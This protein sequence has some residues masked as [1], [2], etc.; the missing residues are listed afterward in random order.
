MP[1]TFFIGMVAL[2]MGFLNVLGHFSAPAAA[3]LLLNLAMISASGP[4]GNCQSRQFRA[5]RVA[6]F[7]CVVIG[8]GMQLGLQIP[9]L[10]R[11]KLRVFR[12]WRIWHPRIKEVL[13]LFGP[14][15][16]G[17]AVY[18]I[19]SV[20]LTLLATMLPQGS[21]SFLYYAD[22]LVQLPL[23]VF[24]IATATAI[25][26]ALSRQA[27]GKQWGAFRSTFAHA[28]ELVLFISLPSMV[29]LIVLREPIVALLF[30]H[31]AFGVDDVQLTADALLYYGMGL[32]S[33]AAVRI[34]LNVYFAIK[35]TRTP[36]RV[37]VVAIVVNL[38]CGA[39]LMGP[40]GHTGAGACVDLGFRYSARNA[41]C[42]F[43]EK[44]GVFRLA[45]YFCVGWPFHHLL[46]GH[47][48]MCVALVSVAFAFNWFRLDTYVA[49][50]GRLR[51]R[52]IG[53]LYRF[54]PFAAG[55]GT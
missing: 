36:V 4:F 33:F 52:R 13:I 25:L 38:V 6:G 20:I 26:P 44:D 24:A 21:V 42:R 53:R 30:Q 48:P 16:F 32:W 2:C 17:A 40:M 29:G 46:G 43:E 39:S 19:N 7:R 37:A 34:V 51:H 1:Y 41:G 47:G 50:C 8:G 9:F 15:F 35:D 12:Q 28:L 11:F 23:G 54:R 14:A 31:G 5:G 45:T 55:T 22:R 27:A 18:Q 10:A 3:P 49:G